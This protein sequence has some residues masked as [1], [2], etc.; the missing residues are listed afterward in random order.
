MAVFLRALAA[1]A[2]LNMLA[3]PGGYGTR[4]NTFPLGSICMFIG[5][6]IYPVGVI[7]K[8]RPYKKQKKRKVKVSPGG[9]EF[10]S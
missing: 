8:S 10:K 6:P 7:L 4:E 3:F 2:E 1:A 5:M 9:H